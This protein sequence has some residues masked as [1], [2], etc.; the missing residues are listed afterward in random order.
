MTMPPDVGHGHGKEQ[1][2][3][4][5]DAIVSPSEAVQIELET[6]CVKND[7]SRIVWGGLLDAEACHQIFV[8]GAVDLILVRAGQH[9]V[10]RRSSV[11]VE[12][13]FASLIVPNPVYTLRGSP[14][15]SVIDPGG[16]R[17]VAVKTAQ[18]GGG[19]LVCTG[20]LRYRTTDRSARCE[21]S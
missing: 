21:P 10:R 18:L 12:N 7:E 17:H 4:D 8:Q 13:G 19:T 3:T 5:S 14:Q 1:C 9:G 16:C 2:P 20:W 6:H 11:Q 15:P